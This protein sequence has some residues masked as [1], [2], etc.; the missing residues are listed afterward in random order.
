MKLIQ[1][2]EMDPAE[3]FLL[4]T[5]DRPRVPLAYRLS[6]APDVQLYAGAIRNVAWQRIWRMDHMRR[7]SA[8]IAASVVDDTGES[9]FTIADV[10]LLPEEDHVELAA[11]VGRALRVCSPWFGY[12]DDMRWRAI[13]AEGG[14]RLWPL[15]GSLADCGDVVLGVGTAWFNE[16]PERYWGVARKDLLDGHLMVYSVARHLIE[17]E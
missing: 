8:M 9:Q 6:V 13:L 11:D 2:P 17:E 15:V 5:E 12:I 4:L 14:R 1:P 7:R 3:L 10:G 16:R